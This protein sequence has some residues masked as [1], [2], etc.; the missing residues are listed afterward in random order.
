MKRDQHYNKYNENEMAKQ[1]NLVGLTI[2]FE[3]I[4]IAF[5]FK[6]HFY[7]LQPKLLFRQF[8]FFIIYFFKNIFL[9]RKFHCIH[10]PVGHHLI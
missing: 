10:H 3:I 5:P 1:I 8:C 2:V 9:G 4:K 6:Y 7:Y